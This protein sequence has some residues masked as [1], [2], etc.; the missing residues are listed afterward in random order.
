[1]RSVFLPED[2]ASQEIAGSWQLP[3]VAG[4]LLIWTI[5]GALLALKTFRWQPRT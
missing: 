5:I 1:M 4:M 3:A 2:F